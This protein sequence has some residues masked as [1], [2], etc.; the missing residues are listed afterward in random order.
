MA[1]K[2]DN[3][4]LVRHFTFNNFIEAFGFMAKVALLAEKYDHHPW[5]SN[6]YNKV[7]IRLT[8]HEA[9]NIITEKDRKLATQIDKLLES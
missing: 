2:E 9:G 4:A 6:I 5:W 1:W 3:N 8:T 7:E